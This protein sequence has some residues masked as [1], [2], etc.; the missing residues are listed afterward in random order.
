ML[1]T[2]DHGGDGASLDVTLNAAVEMCFEA[3]MTYGYGITG[4]ARSGFVERSQVA[5]GFAWEEKQLAFKNAAW[6][7]YKRRGDISGFSFGR[8]TAGSMIGV[9]GTYLA[10]A[11]WGDRGRAERMHDLFTLLAKALPIGAL[12]TIWKDISE[13]SEPRGPEECV[14]IL[15]M[16]AAPPH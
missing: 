13:L 6:G 15:L 8:S 2:I 7:F 14:E 5:D 4:W 11:A 1:E 10:L 9:I 16:E 12:G 3:P